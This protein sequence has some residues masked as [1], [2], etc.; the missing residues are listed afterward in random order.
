MFSIVS[1][2]YFQTE[3]NRFAMPSK[4]LWQ[5]V[6]SWKIIFFINEKK[7]RN[8]RGFFLTNLPPHLASVSNSRE[9]NW[10][11]WTIFNCILCSSHGFLTQ[12]FISFAHETEYSCFGQINSA[13][14]WIFAIKNERALRENPRIKCHKFNLVHD[15]ISFHFISCFLFIPT[16]IFSER[17]GKYQ[18]ERCCTERTSHTL[19]Q[20][21]CTYRHTDSGEHESPAKTHWPTITT[22]HKRIFRRYAIFIADLNLVQLSQ[23]SLQHTVTSTAAD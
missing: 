20:L 21:M 3:C 23:R 22:I 16:L 1:A 5:S 11:T 14:A 7:K 12:A 18:I 13:I 6:C 2:Q 10:W 19:T 4:L 15:F 8:L 9:S 17:N